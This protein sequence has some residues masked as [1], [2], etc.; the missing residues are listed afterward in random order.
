M[1]VVTTPASNQSYP[2]TN[3]TFIWNMQGVY[4]VQSAVSVGSGFL[5]ENHYRGT[6]FAA[7][8][9]T[10]TNVNHPGGGA[11]CCTWPKYTKV[12][13]GPL[14]TTGSNPIYFTST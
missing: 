9:Y 2:K 13:N 1:P 12:W 10:D 8:T 11:R 6:L 5:I 3:K 4:H 14:Y 7:G